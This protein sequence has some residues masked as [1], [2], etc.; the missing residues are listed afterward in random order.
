MAFED[1][2]GGDSM[3]FFGFP[4]LDFPLLQLPHLPI[5][6]APSGMSSLVHPLLSPFCSSYFFKAIISLRCLF[7]CLLI[8]GEKL[9]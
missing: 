3:T 7:S 8:C 6:S 2:Q 1:L 9:L 5:S 4:H